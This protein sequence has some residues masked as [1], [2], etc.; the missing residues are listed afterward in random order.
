MYYL[1]GPLSPSV[2]QKHLENVS[3]QQIFIKMKCA[4]LLIHT[5]FA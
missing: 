3:S 2:L 4:M 5:G 1:A